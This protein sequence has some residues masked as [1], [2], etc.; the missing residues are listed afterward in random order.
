MRPDRCWWIICGWG[1]GMLL[2]A[3]LPAQ[4]CDEA[5]AD[6][7]YAELSSLRPASVREPVAR[8]AAAAYACLDN[9]S[10]WANC[11][12]YLSRGYAEEGNLSQAIAWM[13]TA[14]HRAETLPPK[15]AAGL[16]MFRA[17]YWEQAG[18]YGPAAEDY[19]AARQGVLTESPLKASS[20]RYIYKPLANA[21]TRLG[22]YEKAETLLLEARQIFQDWD[23]I[24]GEGEVLNDLGLLLR[25][26]GQLTAARDTLARGLALPGL[27]PHTRLILRI[28]QAEVWADLRELEGARRS[29]QSLV[30]EAEAWPELQAAAQAALGS[31]LAELGQPLAARAAYEA[32]IAT[33]Q[34]AGAQAPHR[35]LGKTFAALG[36]LQLESNQP[37]RALESYQQGLRWL[38]PG[39]APSAPAD[40]PEAEQLFAENTLSTLLTGKGKALHRLGTQHPE[41]L[42]AAL[43]HLELA[44][45]TETRLEET[46]LYPSA[47]AAWLDARFD[48]IGAAL[49]AAY[50][51]WEQA[52]SRPHLEAI[53]HYSEAGKATWLRRA[54]ADRRAQQQA[55]LPADWQAEKRRIERALAL[56]AHERQHAREQGLTWTESDHLAWQQKRE[57]WLTARQAWE[58]KARR[59]L[60]PQ[61]R[62][63]EV[64]VALTTIQGQLPPETA[65][66]SYAWGPKQLF[67]LVISAEAVTPFRLARSPC[68]GQDIQAFRESIYAPYLNPMAPGDSLNRI[69]QRLGYQLFEAIWPEM[70]LPRHLIILPDGPL[71]Y[72]PFGALLTQLVDGQPEP[73]HLP[74]L[75][76]IHSLTQAFSAGSWYASQE[77]FVP[78][79]EGQLTLAPAY[80][81]LAA[82]E[83]TGQAH[84]RDA[85]GSLAY[86]TLEAEAIY[87]Q[88]GGKLLVGSEARPEQFLEYAPRY[89]WLHFSGHA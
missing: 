83:S 3:A 60:S 69:Y 18:L 53:F 52:P 63:E 9:P 25:T 19:E 73:A 13:D 24:Q 32:A 57:R 2:A 77:Y 16:Y 62:D 29:L 38:L 79:P 11:Y 82:T 86:N 43:A 56:L 28:N 88:M 65:M 70:E 58:A 40:L 34:S 4:A 10:R 75:L 35:Q 81:P 68:L 47:A 6:S 31:V 15:V 33:Y 54:L 55:K 85:L 36:E 42:D 23:D 76:K 48:L 37:A 78:A 27:A 26:T 84:R 87:G 45:A 8:Q 21:H 72:L 5:V 66:L 44:L 12:K 39:F 1:I 59:Q 22:D 61:N 80:P 20:A 7:L 74:Y 89:R 71:G 49:A 30:K 50:D 51:R 14:L 64:S 17:S 46:Y 67:G 41:R